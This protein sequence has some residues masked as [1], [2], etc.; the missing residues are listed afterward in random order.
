MGLPLK[1]IKKNHLKSFDEVVFP[2]GINY[3]VHIGILRRSEGAFT[4]GRPYSTPAR[5][6]LLETWIWP[7]RQF[8]HPGNLQRWNTIF[9]HDFSFQQ[10]G[11]GTL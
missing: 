7:D 5:H 9:L 6:L 11:A 2:T 8:G 10:V 4:R 1:G 3:M